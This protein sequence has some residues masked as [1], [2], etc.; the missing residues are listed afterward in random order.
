MQKYY[1]VKFNRRAELNAKM[2]ITFG[3]KEG[4]AGKMQW[5]RQNFGLERHSAKM[6]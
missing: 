3:S 4:T 2:S 6:F 1:R 5:H